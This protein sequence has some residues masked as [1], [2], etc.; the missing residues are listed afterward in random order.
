MNSEGESSFSA[1]PQIRMVND[2]SGKT[3]FV[4]EPVTRMLALQ[5][6]MDFG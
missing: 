5:V 1:Q 2:S 6:F 3:K 4:M